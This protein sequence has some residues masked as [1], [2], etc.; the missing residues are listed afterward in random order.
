MQE[1][2]V[3][4][5]IAGGGTVGLSAALFLA[6]HGI[7]SLVV[8]SQAGPSRHPRATGLG[9]RTVEFLRETGVEET[10]GAVAVDMLSLIQCV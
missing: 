1:I 8:E 7:A 3:P 10:V 6:H 9:P 2:R 5:L 4:V